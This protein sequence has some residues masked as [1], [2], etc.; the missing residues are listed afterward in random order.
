MPLHFLRYATLRFFFFA[1]PLPLPHALL[2]LPL[3]AADAIAI[4][5]AIIFRYYY[6]SSIAAFRC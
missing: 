1:M 2:M 5:A 3:I 4:F 6:F